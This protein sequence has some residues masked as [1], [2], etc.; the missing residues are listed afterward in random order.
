MNTNIQE[1][2]NFGYYLRNPKKYSR[3]RKPG[4]KKMAQKTWRRHESR[5]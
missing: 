3:I 5:Q 4:M 1:A 2:V